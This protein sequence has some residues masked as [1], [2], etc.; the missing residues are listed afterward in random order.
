MPWQLDFVKVRGLFQV[1]LILSLVFPMIIIMKKKVFFLF[2]LILFCFVCTAESYTKVT[3]ELPNGEGVLYSTFYCFNDL[4]T[5]RVLA[6]ELYN[7]DNLDTILKAGR[8]KRLVM[9]PP[10]SAITKYNYAVM[11]HAHEF[12]FF[13]NR[14]DGWLWGTGR[15]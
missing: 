7:I 3:V 5:G 13:E 8:F 10:G 15:Y 14:D 9:I 6:K 2:I 1:C 12:W 4:Q 11:T